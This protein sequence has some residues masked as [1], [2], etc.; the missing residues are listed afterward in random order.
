MKFKVTK[1]LITR[2]D[3]EMLTTKNV[4]SIECSFTFSDDYEG[5]ELFAVFYRDSSVNCF[6]PLSGGK[7]IIPHEVLEDAGILCVGAYGI[8]NTESTVEKRI[9][10]NYVEIQVESSLS[11]STSPSYAPTPDIWEQYIQE[12]LGYKEAAEQYKNQAQEIKDSM[13]IEYDV[14]PNKVGFKKANESAYTY[15]GDLTGEKGDKGDPGSDA[16][17]TS[18]NIVQALGYYPA[19]MSDIPYSEI[20]SNTTLR[21]THSNKTVLDGITGIVTADKVKNP[22]NITDIVDYAA[23]QAAAYA[24]ISQIP[25]VP[26]A[27]KNPN[28]LTIKIGST[29]VTYDGSAA[30]TVE[31]ADGSEVSY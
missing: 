4:N 20:E 30:K 8:R 23:L 18:E 21:H 9:T 24:I 26:T 2:L 1:N 31:I 15:T 17:V 19:K 10:T 7:C 14:Q 16:N 22:D 25:T 29:T 28:A 11:S 13:V 3:S 27:L 6:V 12:I 5:L